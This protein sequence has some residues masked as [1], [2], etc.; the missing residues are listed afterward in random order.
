MVCLYESSA[1]MKAI[2]G[3]EPDLCFLQAPIKPVKPIVCT[4]LKHHAIWRIVNVGMQ[5]LEFLDW[6][7]GKIYEYVKRRNGGL[8]LM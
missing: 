4:Q 8:K 6:N 1:I 5:I 2:K 3:H 7:V